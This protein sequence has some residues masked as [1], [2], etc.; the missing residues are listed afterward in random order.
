MGLHM[1]IEVN[2]YAFV[3]EREVEELY[4]KMISEVNKK[5]PHWSFAFEMQ[6]NTS[7]SNRNHHC[8]IMRRMVLMQ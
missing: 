6:N 7:V 3:M 8:F 2:L 5:V 4:I 1:E